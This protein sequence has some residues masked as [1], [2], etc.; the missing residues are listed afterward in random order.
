M[1]HVFTKKYRYKH[2]FYFAFVSFFQFTLLVL[3]VVPLH[4]SSL[5]KVVEGDGGGSTRER[6][7]RACGQKEAALRS[8]LASQNAQNPKCPP[9]KPALRAYRRS[10]GCPV[11]PVG[12]GRVPAP[13]C[14]SSLLLESPSSCPCPP[15]LVR[16]SGPCMCLYM[17]VLPSR[18][19][20][21]RLRWSCVGSPASLPSLLVTY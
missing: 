5:S 1:L 10:G 2:T 6:A 3:S 16:P 21:P 7:G 4:G 11:G 18:I 20:P 8:V 9:R 15:S 12:C 13:P 19:V 14:L 17:L